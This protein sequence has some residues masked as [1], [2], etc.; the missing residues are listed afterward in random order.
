MLGRGLRASPGKDYCL[1][2]DH[3]GNVQRL[4]MAED[5]FHWTLEKGRRVQDAKGFKKGERE[6]KPIEC[7]DCKHIF[8]S[9][10]VCPACGWRI[11]APKRDIRA[12]DAELI[13]ITQQRTGEHV[14][15]QRTAE[16]RGYSGWLIY[17]NADGRRIEILP[18]AD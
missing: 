15:R 11:P 13:P 10:P 17:R 7:G 3:A 6:S 18:G 16:Q 2:L 4:G 9:S 5:E 8:R 12:V 14:D 1:V